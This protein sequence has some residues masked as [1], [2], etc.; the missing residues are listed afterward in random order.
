M[1]SVFALQKSRRNKVQFGEN[2]SFCLG[3]S[4]TFN[5]IFV[6][7][8]MNSKTAQTK[9]CSK[10]FKKKINCQIGQN[11]PPTRIWT[12]VPRGK[13]QT[14]GIAPP[15]RTASPQVPFRLCGRTRPQLVEGTDQ[16]RP[17]PPGGA[18]TQSSCVRVPSYAPG[19]RTPPA[20]W[21]G[22]CCGTAARSRACACPSRRRAWADHRRR[23]ALRP[24]GEGSCRRSAPLGLHRTLYRQ[25][26]VRARAEAR[27]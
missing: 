9:K 1:C 3:Q 23:A 13:S 12:A 19:T 21:P 10:C 11:L 22:P 2:D 27:R 5:F 7:T 24:G 15:T 8:S 14:S 17:A 25:P 16:S 18:R 26:A 6:K 20:P 4:Y